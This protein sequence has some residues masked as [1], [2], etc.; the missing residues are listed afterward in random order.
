MNLEQF[1]AIMH[2]V[3]E[4]LDNLQP[5]LTVIVSR[6]SIKRKGHDKH[7]PQSSKREDDSHMQSS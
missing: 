1:L 7:D 3:N 4:L 2:E 5:L 6:F